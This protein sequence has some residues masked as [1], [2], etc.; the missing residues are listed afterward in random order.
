LALRAVEI[1]GVKESRAHVDGILQ[2][3]LGTPKVRSLRR[4]GAVIVYA[5]TRRKADAEGDRL[6][7]LGWNAAVYH[8][9]LSASKRGKVSERFSTGKL[10]VVV[11][12]NAFGMGID[13]ADVRAVVHLGP[14]GSIEAYYQEVGR[15]GRDGE[16]A[17]GL[18]M[19]S[20]Q[21]FPL[22]RRLLELDV[23]G[24]TPDPEVVE[25]KWNTF[26]E[27]MR[28][29]DSGSCRHDGILRYFGDEAEVL[30]GCGRCDVCEGRVASA[31]L[32][33]DDSDLVVRKMLS[34]VAR[35][36]GRLGLGAAVRLAKGS[37]DPRLTRYGLDEV[38]TF[39][40]LKEFAEAWLTR[41]GRRCVSAGWISF[42][43]GDHPMVLL[44]MEGSAVM[45]GTTSPSISLPPLESKTGK[46]S[47]GAQSSQSRS[48]KSDVISLEPEAAALF[49]ALRVHRL[50]VSREHGVP[51]YVVA[52]DRTLREVAVL[53]P[54][55]MDALLEAHGVGPAKAARFGE[56]ILDV[57]ARARS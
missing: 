53:Q 19:I 36:H 2:E 21:D 32:S 56:G 42:T 54:R 45:K 3:V 24:R 39:G 13:R 5:P 35:C 55:D 6:A 51:P 50:E 33:E 52:S 46:R 34:A 47:R 10:E 40:A 23:D 29:A 8:A 17:V 27:L 22:R 26:L 4:S 12:T 9:G 25:H 48:T 28:W 16:P 1:A 31:D 57:V 15:A 38:R 30:G 7:S 44:T 41:L 37:K 20:T 11:A 18:L 14:P 43:T 49:D